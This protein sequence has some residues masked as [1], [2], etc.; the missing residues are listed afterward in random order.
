MQRFKLLFLF[1]LIA[2]TAFAQIL[3]VDRELMEDSV[4]RKNWYLLV[5]ADFSSDKQKG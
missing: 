5:T 1:I 4:P 3:L 2:N